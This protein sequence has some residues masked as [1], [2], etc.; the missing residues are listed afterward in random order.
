MLQVTNNFLRGTSQA[1]TKMGVS[2]GTHWCEGGLLSLPPTFICPEVECPD[3]EHSP[4]WYQLGW[5]GGRNVFRFFFLYLTH[6][7]EEKSLSF[8]PVAGLKT[9]K[10]EKNVPS[11]SMPFLPY[12]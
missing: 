9:T 8:S 6:P 10:G 4:S 11:P 2:T 5:G 1:A 7:K 12:R 3:G